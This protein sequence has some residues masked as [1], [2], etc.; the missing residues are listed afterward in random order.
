MILP[1]ALER[2]TLKKNRIEKRKE[3]LKCIRCCPLVISH[4]IIIAFHSYNQTTDH[5][6]TTTH[7]E[8]LFPSFWDFFLFLFH[9]VQSQFE[10]TNSITCII[11]LISWCHNEDFIC[12]INRHLWV[13]FSHEINRHSME[14]W[15]IMFGK[16]K[17]VMINQRDCSCLAMFSI[18]NCPIQCPVLRLLFHLHV[19]DLS[20]MQVV[21]HAHPG[22]IPFHLDMRFPQLLSQLP[23]FCAMSQKVSKFLS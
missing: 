3:N 1:T 21:N 9:H 22:Y 18:S 15:L 11:E 6:Y 2:T 20:G 7:G 10:S 5:S 8:F 16:T 19:H 13:F 12:K 23:A 4:V 17:W 14:K